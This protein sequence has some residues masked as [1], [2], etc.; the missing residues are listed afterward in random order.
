MRLMLIFCLVTSLLKS[1]NDTALTIPLLG[2]HFGGQLPGGDL[3]KRFGFNLN[4]G[5]CF[6][7]KHSSRFVF[8][9]ESNYLF[10]SQVREDVLQQL[11]T[12]EAFVIDN[13][14]Y[15]ADLRVTERGFNVMGIGGYV[16]DWWS[17][18]QNS[19]VMMTLGVGY[20]QHYINFYDA[21]QK[22]AAVNGKMRYGYDRLT[23]GIALS[24]FIGYLYLSDNRL[25]N[26]YIGAEF[27]EAFT[28]SVRGFN[29]DTGQF[30]KGKRLD[31][32]FGIRV[33]WI[34]PLYK[35]M[36]IGDYYN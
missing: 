23:D 1:Q 22:V 5:G 6:L 31:L 34:L 26:F 9:L 25:S 32:L 28:K 30:D 24:Q 15:P 13:E 7:V 33:G 8:G 17:P 11:T 20:L 3:A 12:P 36:A 19:G 21:S 4:A 16:F 18:N 14:G 2:V 27:Y 29:F 35:K 10:G